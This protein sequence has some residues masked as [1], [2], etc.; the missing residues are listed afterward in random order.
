MSSVQTCIC[1][2]LFFLLYGKGPRIPTFTV[3]SQTWSVYDID[4]ENYRAELTVTLADA[5]WLA[6]CNQW[7]IQDLRQGDAGRI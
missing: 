6:K 5:W 1:E 4:P 7:R 3:L 2:S